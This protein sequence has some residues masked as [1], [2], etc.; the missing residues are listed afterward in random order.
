[1]LA[2]SRS[3][4]LRKFQLDRLS[5]F[6]RLDRLTQ[7]EIH[8]LIEA[9]QRQGLVVQ[10]EVERFRPIVQLTALGADVMRDRATLAR[11]L[12]LPDWLVAKLILCGQVA[13][14]AQSPAPK[15][16]TPS[17]ERPSE[18][19]FPDIDFRDLDELSAADHVI[20]DTRPAYYWTWRLLSAGFRPGECAAIR[21][22]TASDIFRQAAE[23]V[24]HGLD[25]EPRWL[26]TAAELDDLKQFAA[27][28]TIRA[29][30]L[31][32]LMAAQLAAFEATAGN[33]AS[34][35]DSVAAARPHH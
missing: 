6:G 16:A 30:S 4:K 12:D 1:M 18:A 3:A 23:A 31:D 32:P 27:S 20:T 22:M 19:A 7:P 28:D 26:F 11:T 9:L 14:V 25:V 13:D 33:V 5:T 17:L 29:E 15:P 10:T 2:G 8:Q 35:D 34:P 21:Q 24:Q